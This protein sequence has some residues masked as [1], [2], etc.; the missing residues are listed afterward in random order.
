MAATREWDPAR[1]LTTEDEISEY[2]QAVSEYGDPELLQEALG[3][4]ARA[5]GMTQVARDAGLSRESL[6]R[7][8]TKDASPSF[9]TLSKVAG[10]FGL[11]LALRPA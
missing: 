3:N 10:V 9:K 2:L 8:L 6:Y 11:R 7:A 5:R 4:A 1:Y